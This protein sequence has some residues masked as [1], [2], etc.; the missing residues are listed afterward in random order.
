MQ[1]L[2]EEVVSRVLVEDLLVEEGVWLLDEG[3]NHRTLFK[4]L[5]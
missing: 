1:S 4:P 3:E 5:R 2:N